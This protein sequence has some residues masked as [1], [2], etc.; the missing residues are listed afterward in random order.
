LVEERIGLHLARE[1]KVS[2]PTLYPPGHF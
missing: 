1:S 2:A